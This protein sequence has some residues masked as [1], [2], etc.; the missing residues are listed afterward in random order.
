ARLAAAQD[1]AETAFPAAELGLTHPDP[2]LPDNA[3]ALAAALAD[4]RSADLRA[5]RSLIGPHRMD[6]TAIYTA[7]G[8]PAAQCSTGE[9]KALLISLILTNARA[10][11]EDTA[12][13]PLILLDEVAAHLDADRR[14][15]LYHEIC[16]LGAQAWMTGTGPELFDDLA[17][18]AQRLEVT[19]EDGTSRVVG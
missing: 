16:A 12:S 11:A 18:R 1:G 10:L 19:D 2:D 8:V 17:D 15:S 4:S 3:Q 9:Q 6:M 14:A 7:K 13:P 5:G